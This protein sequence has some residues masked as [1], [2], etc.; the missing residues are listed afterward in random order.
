MVPRL[1]LPEA[2]IDG[3]AEGYQRDGRSIKG[4]FGK[5]RYP[6]PGNSPIRM[7]Y[8]YGSSNLG[9]MG[10][11]GRW[12]KMYQSPNLE[13]VVNQSIWNEGE[14]R[15]ADVILPACTNFERWDI[16]EWCGV[17]GF[18][19][20]GQIQL[21]HRIV[22]MQH[23]CIE[24]LGQSKSDFDIFTEL[25]SR[26]G[27]GA[28]YSEGIEDI[29]WCRRMF[30]ASDLPRYIS[31]KEFLKKGYVVLPAADPSINAPV[32]F[33]WFNEG[34]KKDVPEPHP[35][36]AEYRENFGHGLPTPT[37]KFEF[38]C[39]TLKAFDAD[40]PERP[41]IVKYVPS[42][43]GHSSPEASRFPLQLITPHQRFSF[44]SQSDGKHSFLN[45]IEDHRV[46]VDGHYYWVI[47]MNP[48][49]AR[50]RRIRHHGL[51]KVFNDR[52]TVICAAALTERVP[53][54]V[55]HGYESSASYDPKGKP[56]HA[57]DH[58]GTL[59]LITSRRT[60]IRQ[61]HSLAASAALV[62]ILPYKEDHAPA[63]E[64]VHEMAK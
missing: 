9:T 57:P 18:L 17:G 45:N 32:G 38:E 20:H 5:V 27:F 13:F 28:Y 8:R 63:A 48:A 54:G 64:R 41:P 55:V 24:P 30:E 40:D 16:S 60:Q 2:I 42:W 12:A 58:G 35:I 53:A 56:G 31:W 23:K 19:H 37:G 61:S 29:D 21:N 44:H 11:S 47:R 14:V 34:R 62:E 22:V 7:F 43:E 26:L 1:H 49:D 15:F 52:G 6:L 25:G 4:Q 39:E 36:P 33:R 51:V 59:N 46:L 3:A 10:E 50:K